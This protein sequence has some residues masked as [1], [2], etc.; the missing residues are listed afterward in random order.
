MGRVR[1]Q[2]SCPM[3]RLCL[4]GFPRRRN[5]PFE[6]GHSVGEVCDK[7]DT[8]SLLRFAPGSHEHGLT[9]GRR[10]PWDCNEDTAEPFQPCT[11][12]RTIEAQVCLHRHVSVVPGA[13][14]GAVGPPDRLAAVRRDRR[15]QRP[16]GWRRA[17]Q[18]DSDEGWAAQSE[19]RLQR[20]A[21]NGRGA[22]VRESRRAVLLRLHAPAA[23]APPERSSL[24]RSRTQDGPARDA[25]PNL[26]A[27]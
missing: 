13:L 15:R 19:N 1:S 18:G 17:G 7:R 8:S 10:R 11:M 4:P 23:H 9:L 27:A 6:P 3:S 5:S 21:R 20:I 25:A 16:F 2:F 14:A 22:R 26:I 12:E 24:R